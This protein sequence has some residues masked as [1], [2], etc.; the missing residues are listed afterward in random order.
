MEEVTSIDW[1]NSDSEQNR[2]SYSVFK[3]KIKVDD[4][5]NNGE[6]SSESFTFLTTQDAISMMNKEI[7]K[8]Q[9]FL[10][11]KLTNLKFF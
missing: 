2:S 1:L 4:E 7:E 9:V 3:K 10:K 8:L 6:S 11:V 5:K